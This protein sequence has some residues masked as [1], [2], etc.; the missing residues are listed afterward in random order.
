MAAWHD[1]K[2][3]IQALVGRGYI[4]SG[5]YKGDGLPKWLSPALKDC[6]IY[7]LNVKS[8]PLDDTLCI[9]RLAK[10]EKLMHRSGVEEE[11]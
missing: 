9:V 5:N 2:H 3:R 8:I 6:D 4:V 7:V 10:L 11:A 1:L